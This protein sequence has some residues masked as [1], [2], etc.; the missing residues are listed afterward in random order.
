MTYN[1]GPDDALYLLNATSGGP[2][3]FDASEDPTG[4][5]KTN[6]NALPQFNHQVKKKGHTI[7]TVVRTPV[8][9]MKIIQ[10]H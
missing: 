6:P 7:T 2:D 1:P 10:S 3:L 9:R 4:T 8:R 5:G